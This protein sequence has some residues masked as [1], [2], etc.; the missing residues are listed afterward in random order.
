MDNLVDKF[1]TLIPFFLKETD[2]IKVGKVAATVL[3]L[4]Y[5]AHKTQVAF[6][7]PLGNIPG[8]F[9]KRFFEGATLYNTP[10]GKRFEI[11][12]KY[13]QKYGHVVRISPSHIIISDKDMIK[14]ILVTEDFEKGPTY[15]KLRDKDEGNSFNMVDKDLHK[16]RRRLIS[17]AFSVKYIRSL[18]PLIE[19]VAESF[20]KRI[21]LDI[22]NSKDGDGFGTIDVWQLLRCLTLD[23]IGETAFGGTFH[24][25]E[26][27]DH[28]VSR[29]IMDLTSGVEFSIVHPWITKLILMLDSRRK[30]LLHDFVSNII[31]E[32]I[33]SKIKRN[34]I[35][36]ILVDTQ[37][38]NDTKDQLNLEQIMSETTL[39]LIAGSE[40]TSNTIG[41]A[42]IEMCRNTDALRKLY[43][44]IDE[45]EFDKAKGIFKQ[46]QLKSLPYLNAVIKETTRL[47]HVASYGLERITT[48]DV[49][50][51]GDIV[52]P[53]GTRVRCS[54]PVAQVHPDYWPEPLVFKP[55]RW[56]DDSDQKPCTDAFFPFSMGSRNCIGKDF[57]MNEMRLV[58][59]TIIKHFEIKPIP[60]QLIAAEDK[61]HFLTLTIKPGS[62]KINMKSRFTQ[63]DI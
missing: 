23:V 61:R 5:V 35:L 63:E 27:D 62:F 49:V 20:V 29:A 48:Y 36:Q 4:Y 21:N 46:E 38:A 9:S 2:L 11:Y 19:G 42:L 3:A 40:T 54:L 41:F 34:D 28:A 56:L 24:M 26:N 12:K 57:A 15:S 33:E 50:L 13:H 59:A 31:S 52:V 14:Q 37:N 47:N 6:F 51:K 45:V 32:R 58:L 7:N 22:K 10:S 44:E 17:P 53:K 55:E 39:L 1:Q 18:D 60:D 43:A 25:I 30:P 8:P 16:Q